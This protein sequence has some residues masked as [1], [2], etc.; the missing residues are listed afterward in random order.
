MIQ[1][2]EDTYYILNDKILSLQTL[3]DAY[4]ALQK[5]YDTVNQVFIQLI[6]DR[7]EEEKNK[8]KFWQAKIFN[9]PSKEAFDIE[10]KKETA[11]NV[12]MDRLLAMLNIEVRRGY[13]NCPYHEDKTPSC[14][15]YKDSIYCFGCHTSAD[16]IALVQHLNNYT[17]IQSINFLNED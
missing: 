17:F 14:K 7:L 13:I 2:C 15:V 8:V 10:D 16:T 3:I 4:E 1:G 11:K 5:S 12:P 9:P 6:I